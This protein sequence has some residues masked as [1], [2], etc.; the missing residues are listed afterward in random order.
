MVVLDVEDDGEEVKSGEVVEDI[1][2]GYKEVV[3]VGVG[4]VVLLLEREFRADRLEER[5]FPAER[6]REC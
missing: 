4:V 2:E 3:G 5:G 1:G 6:E